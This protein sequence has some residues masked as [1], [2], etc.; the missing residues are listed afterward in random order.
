MSS[1]VLGN[2]SGQWSVAERQWEESDNDS[3]CG[4]DSESRWWQE[5][6]LWRI[7]SV[8]VYWAIGVASDQWRVAERQ[9]KESDND[10][11]DS[12]SR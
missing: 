5:R 8:V 6:F 4:D 12:V 11:N 10:S 1:I 9:W 7:W 2:R 3:A